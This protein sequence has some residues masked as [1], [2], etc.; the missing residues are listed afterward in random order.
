MSRLI[1]S[2]EANN[3][4]PLRN[5]CRKKDL[6]LESGWSQ[7]SLRECPP[8]ASGLRVDIVGSRPAF[9][10]PL[11]RCRRA[12]KSDRTAWAL[13]RSCGA[14]RSTPHLV[15]SGRSALRGVHALLHPSAATRSLYGVSRERLVARLAK[16]NPARSVLKFKRE[17]WT[18]MKSKSIKFKHRSDC[19]GAQRWY[20][21]AGKYAGA[22]EN[23]QIL[24]LPT[25]RP[26]CPFF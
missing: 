23:M 16:I 21:L 14:D 19:I 7:H 6:T 15:H 20:T 25:S 1:F 3:R 17:H 8:T 5:F 26:G 11:G 18:N 2:P 9:A 12:D 22:R 13:A 24:R 10:G 4:P